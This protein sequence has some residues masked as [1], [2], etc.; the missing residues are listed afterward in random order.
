MSDP[1]PLTSASNIHRREA[2]PGSAAAEHGLPN[3]ESVAAEEG[4]MLHSHMADPKM[5]RSHLTQAQLTTMSAAE[6]GS[7]RI[8]QSHATTPASPRTPE[9]VPSAQQT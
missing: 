3:E 5:D 6:E 7:V 4:T 2:C 8:V 1:R 9:Y